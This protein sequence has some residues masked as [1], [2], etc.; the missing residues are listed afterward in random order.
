MR[1]RLQSK[2]TLSAKWMIKHLAGKEKRLMKDF[3]HCISKAVVKF[4][5]ENGVFVISLENLTG[6]RGRTNNGLRKK[7][8]YLHNN[9]VFYRLQQ[10]IEYKAKSSGITTEYVN[11][12]NTSKA[13]C[14]CNNISKNNTNGLKFLCETCSFELNADLNGAR[15][16]EHR[17]RGYR[18]IL[19][20]QGCLST[21]HTDNVV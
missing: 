2:G 21:T 20:S 17:T 5:V 19:E 11:P 7:Q 6:I 4:A 16:I 10:F 15:N 8:K 13:F 9:W 12:G 18:Y 1:S 3:N 14:R